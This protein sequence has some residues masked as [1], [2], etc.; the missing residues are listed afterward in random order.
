MQIDVWSDVACPW[1]YL[2]KRRL[3]A[4]LAATGVQADVAWHAFE[5][6][7]ELPPA[8]LPIEDWLGKRYPKPQLDQMHARMAAMGKD[9]GI[10]FQF[11]KRTRAANTRLAHRAIAIAREL[12]GAALQAAVVEACFRANFTLG[13]DIADPDALVGALASTGIDVETLRGK[14]AASDALDQ[15]L[16]DERLA[17]RI[18]ITGVPFFIADGKLALSGAQAPDVFASFLAKARDVAA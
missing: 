13:V 2:G 10:D 6:A 4:A 12:G 16:A 17:A 15:V 1:C 14:L 18:G 11:D 7:P 8:G 3:E 5:L 9:A